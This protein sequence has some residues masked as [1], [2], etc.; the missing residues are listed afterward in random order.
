ARVLGARREE[1]AI[2]PSV[3]AALASIASSLEPEVRSAISTS[4]LDFPTVAYQWLANRDV[5]VRFAESPD[6][7]HV[8][9]DSWQ[10]T[11]DEEVAVV[12]TSHVFYS[13]GAI[14][15]VAS[16]A[17]VAHDAGALVVV[18]AYQ[19]VGQLPTD[20]RK[21][22]ADF[23][24]TGGL[25]WLLGGPGIAYLYARSEL[26]PETAPRSTGWFANAA[27]FDFDPRRFA[28]H[29]DARRLETGTPG[30]S[31]VAAAEAGLDIVLEIGVDRIR[32]R[33]RELVDDLV[34]RATDAG[35]PYRGASGSDDRAGIVVVEAGT[36]PL[37]VV[38]RLAKDGIIVDARHDG[39]RVSPYFYNTP[40]E[41]ETAVAA[42][43]TAGL[44]RPR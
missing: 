32:T 29:R 42:L 24:L 36:D 14:Q 43:V 17:K 1:I 13:S 31:A 18:D 12:A 44:S 20:P 38:Q 8:P 22:G 33:Q 37:L 25:K 11:I 19:S 3:S 41:N 21:L 15:D 5:E 6:R 26:V 16:L 9:L 28:Y 23:L 2:A 35:L 30:L 27:Q 7:I 39:I 4:E 10:D 40:E 34:D